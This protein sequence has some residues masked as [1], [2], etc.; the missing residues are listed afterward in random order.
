QRK[1]LYLA[2]RS[3]KPQQDW[4]IIGGRTN[5]GE[6][7]FAS[8]ARCF[9]RETKLNIEPARFTFVSMDR[10]L[11]K[12][13]KQEPQ[14][15]GCD[16]FSYTFC[17]ELTDDELRRAGASL[18]PK[19]YDTKNGLQEFDYPRLIEANV[20]PVLLDLYNDIFQ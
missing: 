7:P 2:K 20:H 18:D 8:V 10:Y 9:N 12:E 17:V 14:K 15:N 5:A 1:T 4:W 13:R 3:V 19:E 11:W 16:A 6:D